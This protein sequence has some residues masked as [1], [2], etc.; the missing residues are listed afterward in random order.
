M[1]PAYAAVIT[2]VNT[3]VS[4]KLVWPHQATVK[5]VVSVS[6]DD[7]V[8]NVTS[9]DVGLTYYQCVTVSMVQCC[10]TSTETV[11]LIRTEARDGHL[12]FHTAPEL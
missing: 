10:F 12:D 7:V 11:R 9:S 3:A 5:A 2:P 4:L 6:D 1:H 8:L